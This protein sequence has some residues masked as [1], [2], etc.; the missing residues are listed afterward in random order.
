MIYVDG[1][2]VPVSAY[3]QVVIEELPRAILKIFGVPT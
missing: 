1:E 3:L 2:P